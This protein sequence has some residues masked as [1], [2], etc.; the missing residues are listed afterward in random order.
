MSFDRRARF[1]K[2]LSQLYLP[3]Y[4]ALCRELP[5]EWQPY[6]GIRSFVEQDGLYMK[7]RSLPG[8]IIT[9]ARGSESPHCYGCASDWVMFDKGIPIWETS[10]WEKYGSVV[11][12]VG[13]AWG[14]VFKSFKDRPHNELALA[15]S[16]K[17]VGQ[18]CSNDGLDAA[19]KFIR[20]NIEG[21]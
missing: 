19:I 12:K 21:K 5:D 10:E 7:G 1:R 3:F 6:M 14:G 20:Q 18:V 8:N 16:W 15:V 17:K 13:L 9:Y 11:E 2:G 4:D